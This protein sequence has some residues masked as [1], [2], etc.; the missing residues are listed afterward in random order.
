M[1]LGCDRMFQISVTELQVWIANTLG[2]M[3]V[4]STVKAFLLFRGEPAMASYLQGKNVKLVLVAE[5]SD[6]LG[7]DSLVEGGISTHWLPLVAPLLHC[8]SQYLLLLAWGQQLITKLHSILHKQWIYRNSYI[9]YKGKEGWTMPQIQDINDK[10]DGYSCL[11][12]VTLLPQHRFL[13]EANFAV[14][15][16]GPTSQCLL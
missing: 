6:H 9:H 16:N 5:C 4:A 14:L 1:D 2:E 8:Q 15:G 7:W 11:D 3:T 10:V 13:F 12:P